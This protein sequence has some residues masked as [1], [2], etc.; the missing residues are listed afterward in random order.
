M[1]QVRNGP[2]TAE[3]IHGLF[4]A[5]SAHSL[6]RTVAILFI[7]PYFM[8]PRGSALRDPVELRV[9]QDPCIGDLPRF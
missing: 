8:N 9:R 3:I 7:V 6:E 4:F 1:P 2:G 5:R